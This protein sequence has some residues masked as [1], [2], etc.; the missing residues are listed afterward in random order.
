MNP[1]NVRLDVILN[2]EIGLSKFLLKFYKLK[3]VF[4]TLPP[5]GEIITNP[6]HLFYLKLLQD[7]GILKIELIK[8]NPWNI[9]LAPIN[10]AIRK[11]D[12]L[13]SLVKEGLAN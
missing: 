12:Q 3:S 6:T 8:N 11:D 7:V 10:S 5:Y 9:S 2:Y 4:K 1:L 13:L